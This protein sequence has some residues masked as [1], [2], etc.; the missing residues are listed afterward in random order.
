[1]TSRLGWE[2]LKRLYPEQFETVRPQ[3]INRDEPSVRRD[4][5]RRSTS[6]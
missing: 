6:W 2:D 4:G 1:M 5:R 3:L